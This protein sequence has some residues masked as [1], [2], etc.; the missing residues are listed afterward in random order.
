MDQETVRTICHLARLK[1]DDE[2]SEKIESDL[3]TI[4]A[5]IGGL[6]S[7]DTSNIEPLYSPLEQTAVKH[8]DVVNSDN[9]KDK[10]LAN[11]PLSNDDYFLVPRVVE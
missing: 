9:C 1:I 8:E 10:Y 7:F 3:D 6:S 2:K 11:S 5:L 4:I